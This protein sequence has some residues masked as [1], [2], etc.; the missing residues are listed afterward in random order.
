MRGLLLTQQQKSQ[1]R[2]LNGARTCTENNFSGVHNNFPFISFKYNKQVLRSKCGV[3]NLYKVATLFHNFKI[4]CR[5]NQCGGGIFG[6]S[7]PSLEDYIN[8]GVRPNTNR[9]P[10]VIGSL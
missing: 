1:I 7:A 9:V 10:N 4:C 5:G 6:I 2:Q 3:G 8:G